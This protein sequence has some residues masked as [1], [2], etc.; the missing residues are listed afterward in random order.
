MVHMLFI[1]DI[2]LIGKNTDGVNIGLAKQREV[3]ESIELNRC[4]TEYIEY[5]FAEREHF[6]NSER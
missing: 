5:D 2:V 6:G 1:N 3:F 4:K